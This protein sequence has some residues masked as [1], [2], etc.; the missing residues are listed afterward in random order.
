M[1]SFL[2]N[3][4]FSLPVRFFIEHM[5]LENFSWFLFKPSSLMV[6]LNLARDGAKVAPKDYAVCAGFIY[7]V[8]T[9]FR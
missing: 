7:R 4:C 3:I 8:A 1:F 2:L 5:S 9:Q 6:V